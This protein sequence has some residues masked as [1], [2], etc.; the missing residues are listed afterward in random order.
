MPRKTAATSETSQQQVEE[1][2][3]DKEN[4]SADSEAAKLSRMLGSVLKYLSDDDIEEIDIQYLLENTE[5]LQEWWDQY[6]E[7]NRKLVEEE[8][9]K[10]LGE[11]SLEELEGIRQ[12]IKEK[13]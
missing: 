8:I 10:S 13:Q 6:R 1:L 7:N 5:G 12:K 2:L 9:K 11:L 4:V 3:P